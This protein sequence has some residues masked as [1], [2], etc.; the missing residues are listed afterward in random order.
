MKARESGMPEEEWW[1][2]FFSPAEALQALG[3]RR[4]MSD[5]VDF[6]CGYGTFTV[7]AAQMIDGTVYAYDIEPEMIAE[8]KRKTRKAGLFNVEAHVRDF[9]E[10][11][12]GMPDQTVDYAMLFNILHAE[13]P[14]ELINEAKRILRIGG[15]LAIM[16]W[17]HDPGTPRGPSMGIRPRPEQCAAWAESVGLIIVKRRIDMPPYHYGIVARKG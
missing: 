16:H 6:G 8:T 10:H 11:G 13:D 2:T 5:V 14:T 4:G 12:S 15:L 7:P 17:N 3:L 1:Q 9:V